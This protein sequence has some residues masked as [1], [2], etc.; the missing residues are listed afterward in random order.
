MEEKEEGNVPMEATTSLERDRGGQVT[1]G[2]RVR[3]DRWGRT[4]KARI[5]HAWDTGRLK[6]V[7]ECVVCPGA[8]LLLVC[9]VPLWHWDLD[10]LLE[11]PGF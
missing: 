1:Q 7:S 9:M 4:G 2:T 5:S 8:L 11:R 10:P 6:A 3:G